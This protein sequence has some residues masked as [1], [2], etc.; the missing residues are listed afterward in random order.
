MKVVKT[1]EQSMDQIIKAKC[2]DE[3]KNNSDMETETEEYLEIGY[4][5]IFDIRRSKSIN[6]LLKPDN[7]KR[8]RIPVAMRMQTCT[9]AKLNY[10]TD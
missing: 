6:D 8:Y 7:A 9:N 3:S 10:D 5:P 1:I 2:N 4:K